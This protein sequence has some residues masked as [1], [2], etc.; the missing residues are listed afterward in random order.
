MET[1]EN[2][3]KTLD[4]FKFAIV[5]I[6]TIVVTLLFA[7]YFKI[8]NIF[9]KSFKSQQQ[10]CDCSQHDQLL[11]KQESEQFANNL[12]DTDSSQKKIP[13]LPVHKQ[14][15]KLSFYYSEGCGYC[16]IFKPEWEKIKH[17]VANTKLS[18]ILELEENDC[19]K[20]PSGCAE[21]GNYI[22]GFPTVLLT[23]SDNT[24]VLYTDYPRTH[25]SVFKFLK[26]NM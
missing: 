4:V 3:V 10:E 25:D 2:F 22:R 23:K 15:P 8:C 19:R 5:I 11:E 13:N 20:N 12:T 7:N 21:N 18:N 14:K 9:A 16:K 6:V 1:L 24:K 26:E 17:T